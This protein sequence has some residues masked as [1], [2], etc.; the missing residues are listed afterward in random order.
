[1]IDKGAFFFGFEVSFV[2]VG[3]VSAIFI[4]RGRIC[5]KFNLLMSRTG[6]KMIRSALHPFF[7]SSLSTFAS[8]WAIKTSVLTSKEILYDNGALCLFE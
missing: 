2:V 1:M 7:L 4:P 3:L 5:W 8:A 6:L